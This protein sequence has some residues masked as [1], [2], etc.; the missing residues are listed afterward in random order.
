MKSR[1]FPIILSFFFCQFLFSQDQ[2]AEISDPKGAIII[3]D[4]KGSVTVTDN[5]TGQALD[6]TAV[7]P[8]CAGSEKSFG[9]RV[10]DV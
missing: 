2:P 7:S 4:L 9:R 5:K 8:P 10:L 1:T 3:A 6:A